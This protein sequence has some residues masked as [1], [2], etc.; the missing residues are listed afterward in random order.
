ML[1]HLPSLFHSPRASTRLPRSGV[2]IIELLIVA[3]VVM[4]LLVLAIP[5]V[6]SARIQ[7]SRTV[8][9]ANIRSCGVAVASYADDHR[10]LPPF[11]SLRGP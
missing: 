4:V 11:F 8:T 3:G 6:R 2:T 5:S 7:A 1:A 9:L 10:E